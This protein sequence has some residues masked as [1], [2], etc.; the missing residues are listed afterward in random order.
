MVVS[1]RN[2]LPTTSDNQLT[3]PSML[4]QKFDS[5]SIEMCELTTQLSQRVTAHDNKFDRIM[6]ELQRN[7][8]GSTPNVQNAPS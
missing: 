3:T 5:F 4:E 8:T 2:T 6:L 1:T 7:N